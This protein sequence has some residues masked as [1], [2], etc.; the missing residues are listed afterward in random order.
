M[1]RATITF[2]LVFL[3]LLAVGLLVTSNPRTAWA[4]DDSEYTN[5]NGDD[6]DGGVSGLGIGARYS[7]VNNQETDETTHMGGAMLRLRSKF[8]GLEGGVDYRND[9][10]GNDI[11]LKTWPV[12]ASLL[13]F[14]LKH[15]Y[16]VAGLGWYHTTLDFPDESTFDDQTDSQ[17]GYHLGAGVEVPVVPAVR[18][19]GDVRW[20]FVDY[21]FDDIPDTFGNVDADAVAFNAGLLFYLP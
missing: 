11:D 7:N 16:G 8:L 12:T 17:L 5:D 19:T 1:I 18:L 3:M 4:D 9:D 6:D 20:L 15:I 10:L 2:V 21:E 14:P 13:V